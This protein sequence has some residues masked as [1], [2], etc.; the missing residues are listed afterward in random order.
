MGHASN[1]VL[2]SSLLKAIHISGSRYGDAN[3]MIPGSGT[4]TAHRTSPSRLRNNNRA[5]PA[6]GQSVAPRYLVDMPKQISITCAS[7]RV[8]AHALTSLSVACTTE[9]ST[10]AARS[11]SGASGLTA[12]IDHLPKPAAFCCAKRPALPKFGPQVQRIL[13]SELLVRYYQGRHQSANENLGC[14]IWTKGVR[15][16]AVSPGPMRTEGTEAMGK[17]SKVR[18]PPPLP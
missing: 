1:A 8:F 13:F 12:V 5:E 11:P 3:P 4:R 16:N 15:L 2:A 17:G 7:R 6:D 14:R 9:M 18:L 10:A